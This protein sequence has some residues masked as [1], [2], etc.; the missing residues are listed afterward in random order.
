MCLNFWYIGSDTIRRFGLVGVGVACWGKCIT[1]EVDFEIT[2]AQ[3]M[4]IVMH[5]LLFTVDQDK[6]LS[7]HSQAPYLSNCCIDSCH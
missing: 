5:S 7:G 2:C 1:V 3:V 4:P 6:E